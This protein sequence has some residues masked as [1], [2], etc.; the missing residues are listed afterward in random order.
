[1]GEPLADKGLYLLLYNYVPGFDGIRAPA[2]L[3]M[4]FALFLAALA[5]L[6]ARA[7]ERKIQHASLITSLSQPFASRRPWLPPSR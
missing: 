4:L 1:M 7:I 2:R 3:G 6:G 5:S